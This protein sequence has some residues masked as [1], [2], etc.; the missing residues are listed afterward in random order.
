MNW[1][2]A[3]LCCVTSLKN[4][5]FSLLQQLLFANS[6]LSKREICVHVPSAHSGHLS[7]LS[8]YRSHA[9]SQCEFICAWLCP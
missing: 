4:T 6:F 3:D 5:D 2:M 7:V 1:A 9:C 8:L